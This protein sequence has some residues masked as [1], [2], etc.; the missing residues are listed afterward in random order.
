[1]IAPTKFVARDAAIIELCRNRR[2]LH[3]GCVGFTDH[4][5]EE[6]LARARSSL[7]QCLSDSCDC[8]G[9]DNDA[10]SIREL[11]ARGTFTNVWF[12]DA[13]NLDSL[14][15]LG[16][17]DVVLASDLIEHLGNPGQMLEGAQPFIRAGGLLVISTPNAFGLPNF[18]RYALGRYREG[19]QHTL[20][21]NFVTLQHMLERYSYRV[22]HMMT[23]YQSI[24]ADKAGW[25]LLPGKMLFSALPKFGGTLLAVCSRPSAQ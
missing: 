22:Q 6:K 1:M 16:T 20:N 3:L 13:E 9:I 7:H 17:F 15:D 23:C 14:R 18:V 2:V 21:F 8:V 5:I 11:Q 24:S 12:G 10:A 25:K 19:A 4:P